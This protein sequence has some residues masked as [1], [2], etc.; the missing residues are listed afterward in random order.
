MKNLQG[1]G[2]N[3]PQRTKEHFE[4]VGCKS[5]HPHTSDSRYFQNALGLANLKEKY[6]WVCGCLRSFLPVI[7]FPFNKV[8]NSVLGNL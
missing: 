6:R 1:P 7:S 3:H 5:L 4:P 8:A 2:N